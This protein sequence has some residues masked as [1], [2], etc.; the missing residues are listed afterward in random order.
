MNGWMNKRVSEC[1][2]SEVWLPIRI[3]EDV[4]KWADKEVDDTWMT[5]VKW[6]LQLQMNTGQFSTMATSGWAGMCGPLSNPP[7]NVQ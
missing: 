5:T 1:I 6:T 3:G 4:W 2:K 7:R